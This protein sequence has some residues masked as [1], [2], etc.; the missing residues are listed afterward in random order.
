MGVF[1]M[2]VLSYGTILSIGVIVIVGVKVMVGAGVTLTGVG[3]VSGGGPIL[4]SVTTTGAHP[5]VITKSPF[6]TLT[7]NCKYLVKNPSPVN[8]PSFACHLFDSAAN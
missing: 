3:V 8:H 7:I 1:Q 6:K 4:L 5:T 2:L